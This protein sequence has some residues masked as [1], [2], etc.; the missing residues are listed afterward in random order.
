[1]SNSS[2]SRSSGPPGLQQ[3]FQLSCERVRRFLSSGAGS[4]SP[5]RT[6]DPRPGVGGSP[7]EGPASAASATAT[8]RSW[9]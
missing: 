6:G 1:M 2:S 4:S 8:R 7:A 5:V 3:A 9:R